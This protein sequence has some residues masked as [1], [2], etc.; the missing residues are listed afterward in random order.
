MSSVLIPSYEYHQLKH[1]FAVKNFKN[2]KNFEN[3][4]KSLTTVYQ[5]IPGYGS[6]W[7][8][9]L[10]PHGILNFGIW[11]FR[12]AEVFQLFCRLRY[13]LVSCGGTEH[14]GR[15]LFDG[16]CGGGG[17][18]MLLPPIKS[19]H[20]KCVMRMSPQ[21]FSKISTALPGFSQEENGCSE[22]MREN[23]LRWAHPVSEKLVGGV[24]VFLIYFLF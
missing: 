18:A 14:G 2:E 7:L 5:W 16:R 11:D 6:T 13:I 1:H 22:L 21:N 23:E 17:G 3:P 15:I 4:L 8:V 9:Q 10:T 24:V 12:P 20:L 19:I